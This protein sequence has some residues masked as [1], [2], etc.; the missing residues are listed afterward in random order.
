MGSFQILS[1]LLLEQSTKRG[2]E[3]R[4]LDLRSQFGG[5]IIVALQ[6]DQSFLLEVGDFFLELGPH[7]RLHRGFQFFQLLLLLLGDVSFLLIHQLF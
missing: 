7:L 3:I 5:R 6:F 4:F 2:Q 1:I